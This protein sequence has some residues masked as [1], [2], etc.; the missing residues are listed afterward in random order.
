[1]V[2]ALTPEVEALRERLRLHKLA[3]EAHDRRLLLELLRR[4][5]EVLE[6]HRDF[7][8]RLRVHAGVHLAETSLA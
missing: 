5:V 7:L 2:A 6:L 8:L 4:G 1:M 3:Q